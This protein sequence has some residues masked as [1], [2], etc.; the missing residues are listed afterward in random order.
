MGANIATF[1]LRM[2]HSEA[3][4]KTE[5]VVDA[6]TQEPY[7]IPG[8]IP[9]FLTVGP[10]LRSAFEQLKEAQKGAE[11]GDHMKTAARNALR[12]PYN[13]IIIDLADFVEL[14]SRKDPTLPYKAG[15]EYFW[16]KRSST[17]HATAVLTAPTL[18]VVNGPD[19]GTVIGKA[20]PVAGAKS[21]EMQYTYGDP[22]VESNWSYLKVHG[23]ASKMIIRALEAGRTC[24]LRVRG[25]GTSEPGP[26]SNYITLIVT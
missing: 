17:S 7:P 19:R 22:T 5:P 8:P 23:R 16:R 11:T 15:L 14:A 1:L 3:I 26:W 6:F 24:S 12:I 20:T 2:S 9:S 25:V 18:T 13:Q 4:V 10:A 21:Y